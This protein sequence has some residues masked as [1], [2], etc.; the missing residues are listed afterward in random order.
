VNSVDPRQMVVAT[1]RKGLVYADI[2]P[3]SNVP[4]V[5]SAPASF[6]PMGVSENRD[7]FLPV[8]TAFCALSRAAFPAVFQLLSRLMKKIALR[9]RLLFLLDCFLS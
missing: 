8:H 1:N 9:V 4:G 7:C 2:R 5:A 3:G 6:A